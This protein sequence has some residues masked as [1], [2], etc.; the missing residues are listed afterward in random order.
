MKILIL[1]NHGSGKT[2]LA[3]EIL[4]KYSNFQYFCAEQKP[5]PEYFDKN[6]PSQLFECLGVNGT[7]KCLFQ[8]FEIIEIPVLII[9]LLVDVKTCLKRLENQGLLNEEIEKQ[10]KEID[11]N[12]HYGEMSVKWASLKHSTL[13]QTRNYTERDKLFILDIVD[14]Y[15][16]K[17]QNEHNSL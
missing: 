12:L 7:G 3:N 10:V 11:E 13:L 15:I 5:I 6:S 8:F 1:G 14:N 2:T 16:Q 17:Y 4:Q 9:S